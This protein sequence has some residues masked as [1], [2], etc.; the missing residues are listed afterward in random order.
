MPKSFHEINRWDGGL[1]THF[2]EADIDPTELSEISNWSVSKIGRIYT[3]DG[4]LVDASTTPYKAGTDEYNLD[5]AYGIS[6]SVVDI[7]LNHIWQ[8]G[9]YGTDTGGP[10][11]KRE[12]QAGNGLLIFDADYPF[13][14]ND[15]NNIFGM[16]STSKIWEDVTVA[17]TKYAV[18][19]ND[20]GEVFLIE[21][22]STATETLA[23]G[24]HYHVIGTSSIAR[25]ADAAPDTTCRAYWAEGALRVS[26]T[27]HS[28]G[29]R[30][31]WFG[32]CVQTRFGYS[33]WGRYDRAF[34]RWS[35]QN[36]SLDPPEIMDLDD[37]NFDPSSGN[38][39]AHDDVNVDHSAPDPVPGFYGVV[40]EVDYFPTGDQR[41]KALNL[42][43]TASTGKTDGGWEATNYEFAQT[44]VYQGNQESLP[45]VMRVHKSGTD[46]SE[47]Y[48]TLDPQQYWTSVQVLGATNVAAG[49]DY[50]D[51]VTGA[52]IYIRKHNS[53]KRWTLFLDC[54]FS[55]GVRQNTFEDFQTSWVTAGIFAVEV[56]SCDTTD[57][58]ET[59][60]CT[61]G[62]GTTIAWYGGASDKITLDGFEGGGA[63]S[64]AYAGVQVGCRVTGRNV[65]PGT[66]VAS[67]DSGDLELEMD[68]EAYGTYTGTNNTMGFENDNRNWQFKTSGYAA[69]GLADIK[70][71]SPQTYESLNGFS[72]DSTIIS[73]ESAGQGWEDATVL[74]RRCF[75]VGMNY[76]NKDS[77]Q[78]ELMSDRLFYSAIAKYDTFPVGNWIDI[79][80]N[81]GESFKAVEGLANRLLAFKETTLYVINVQ[82]PSDG[83][84]Y[85][86][87]EL[88]GMGVS[89]P[90]SIAK[91]D[92]GIFFANLYGL[93]IYNAQGIPVDVAE[94]LDKSTWKTDLTEADHN[95]T[96]GY[97][98]TSEQVI[99]GL[100]GTI[101]TTLLFPENSKPYYV[102]DIKTRSLVRHEEH[103][104]D[105]IT[106]FANITETGELVWMGQGVPDASNT[107]AFSFKKYTSNDLGFAD[108][109]RNVQYFTTKLMDFG[110]PASMKKFYSLY[111]DIKS[112][113][114]Y[115]VDFIV[116]GV[117]TVTKTGSGSSYTKIKVDISGAANS[118]TF[119]LKVLNQA[120]VDVSINSITLEYRTLYKRVS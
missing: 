40:S 116:N 110:S 45:A 80:I 98:G 13:Y 58:D 29:S 2:D 109:S 27:N 10:G 38:G 107:G 91:T 17:S 30:V 9:S 25:T 39:Q 44:L 86:E 67:I 83:G 16:D 34:N 24:E 28:T 18:V 3:T 12:I 48:K 114:T 76:V 47:G 93:Y 64:L 36:A 31:K 79:G 113:G 119:Q 41:G 105:D 77:G 33:S 112:S 70:N 1:N 53:N 81:D 73:F 63:S 74:N 59:M 5:L 15:Y 55:R 4:Q 68:H 6:T 49:L 26:D 115:D 104:S 99:V 92:K 96:V 8:Q 111:V 108:T 42:N 84:W 11:A 43:V 65:W 94:K 60:E 89:G 32:R 19:I 102:Y 97:D 71:P 22:L 103:M 52:R 37:L 72:P 62:T 35:F 14:N 21:G 95:I 46:Y 87:A 50:N 100:T 117:T 88:K 69:T 82:N 57:E 51:R 101:E 78:T 85:L 118:S 56:P 106:N 20:H 61:G 7:Y 75:A 120:D 54:D 90:N 66:K 23:F